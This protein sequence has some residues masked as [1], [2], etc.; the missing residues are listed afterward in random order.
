MWPW[1]NHNIRNLIALALTGVV[2]YLALM[3]AGEARAVLTSTFAVL[4]GSLWGER[5]AL[6]R[7]GED[8]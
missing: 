4:C 5:S 8:T 6:K 2:C 1:L 3:G 7:P